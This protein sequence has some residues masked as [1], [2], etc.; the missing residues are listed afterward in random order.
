MKCQT[1]K[2]IYD[3]CMKT[4]A[5]KMLLFIISKIGWGTWIRTKINGVRVRCSTIKLFPSKH[6][7]SSVLADFTAY[8]TQKIFAIIE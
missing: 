5:L 2:N 1:F 4:A 8:A 7:L 6:Q 3:Y